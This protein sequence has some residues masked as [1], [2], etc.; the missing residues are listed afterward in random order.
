VTPH[1]SH[2]LSGDHFSTAGFT[3]SPRRSLARTSPPPPDH[4]HKLPPLVPHQLPSTSTWMGHSGDPSAL[5][6]PPRALQPLRG[7]H[8]P[9]RR[10]PRPV[11][12]LYRRC[13]P[14]L[15]HTTMDGLTDE[16]PSSLLSPIGFPSHCVALAVAPDPPHRRGSPE[17]GPRHRLWPW[18][19]LPC[20]YSTMGHQP[21]GGC[22]HS[23]ADRIGPR[24]NSNLYSFLIYLFESISNLVQTH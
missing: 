18:S 22:Q 15:T 19:C 1:P 13:C 24:V 2:Q 21:M 10:L 7:P 8:R 11:V 16:H 17:T 6:P 23:W 4:L 14:L 20:L 5:S 12:H 9:P 3:W